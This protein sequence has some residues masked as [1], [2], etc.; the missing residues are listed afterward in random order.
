MYVTSSGPRGDMY[1]ALPTVGGELLAGDG[2]QQAPGP[3]REFADDR[4][5]G[6]EFGDAAY[7]LAGEQGHR[8]DVSGRVRDRCCPGGARHIDLM[9][10][11]LH[12]AD[13]GVVERLDGIDRRAQDAM[14]RV[15]PEGGE[16]IAVDGVRARCGEHR[17]LVFGWKSDS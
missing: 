14:R 5:G 6:P 9:A 10:A 1:V 15:G 12:R 7:A 13:D 2:R 8:L 4:A 3:G 11:D 17:A 16:H